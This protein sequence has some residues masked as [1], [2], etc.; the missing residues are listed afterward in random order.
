LNK[1]QCGGGSTSGLHMHLTTLHDINLRKG[2]VQ[3]CNLENDE[4]EFT[5]MKDAKSKFLL[6]GSSR[7]IKERNFQKYWLV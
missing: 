4:L 7:A 3:V 6:T 5:T 2:D 1:I